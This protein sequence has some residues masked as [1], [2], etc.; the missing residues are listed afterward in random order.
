MSTFFK[1]VSLLTTIFLLSLNLS[2]QDLTNDVKSWLGY[3]L[4]IKVGKRFKAKVGQLYSFDINSSRFGFAQ[5]NFVFVYKLA[6]RNYLQL[7]YSNS[8][9]R[10]YSYLRKLGFS[11]NV[12]GLVGYQRLTLNYN[13]N[14]NLFK[15]NKCFRLKHSVSAQFFFP[16]PVKHRIR[17]VYTA[18][19]YYSNPKW[20]LKIKPFFANSLHYYLGGRPITYYNN[21]GR[22]IAYNSPD[23][24][25]R[26]RLK[27]GSS[28]APLKKVPFTITL[29]I[30]FQ[31]EFNNYLFPNRSL[32]Y[33]KPATLTNISYP[34]KPLPINT[35]LPFNNYI[36]IGLHL[37]YTI[38]VK[39]KKKKNAK[40]N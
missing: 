22:I 18:R 32:N 31:W 36:S 27:T 26:I 12:L 35:K 29:Y 23:G 14:H 30:V 4:N 33:K 1:S 28:L 7:E 3:S 9:Y 40:R 24:F 19:L 8:Q 25:H 37:S 17:F 34:F 10:W 15:N 16:Q 13:G 2:A 6:T 11:E 39:I 5:T 21:Q 20:P 38:K